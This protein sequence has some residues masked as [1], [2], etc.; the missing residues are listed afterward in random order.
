MNSTKDLEMDPDSLEE[1]NGE[2]SPIKEEGEEEIA[3]WLEEEKREI[4]I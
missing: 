2:S 1:D 4:I 3:N